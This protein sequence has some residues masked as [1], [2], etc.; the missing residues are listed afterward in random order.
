MHSAALQ[1]CYYGHQGMAQEGR[2]KVFVVVVVVFSPI[3]NVEKKVSGTL[4]FLWGICG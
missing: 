1:Y 2:N 4:F 3:K